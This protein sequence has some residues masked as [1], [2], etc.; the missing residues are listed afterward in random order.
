VIDSVIFQKNFAAGFHY[1]TMSGR[2]AVFQHRI[3][4]AKPRMLWHPQFGLPNY[5]RR[6]YNR[7]T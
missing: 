7:K 4:I 5:G 6:P 2:P 1:T 3:K